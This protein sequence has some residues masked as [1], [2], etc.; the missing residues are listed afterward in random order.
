MNLTKCLVPAALLGTLLATGAVQAD[1]LHYHHGVNSR[2]SHQNARIEQGE[3]SGELT[4]REANRLE[5]RD[6]RIGR[7][8]A[9]M[10]ASGGRFTGRERARLR[11]EEN[12]TSGAIYGDKHNYRVR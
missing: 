3:R 11:R 4:N 10:R 9:R 6:A 8:E 12:R 7:Q 5:H 1:P 2:L